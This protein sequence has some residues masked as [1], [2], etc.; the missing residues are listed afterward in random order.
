MP[1]VGQRKASRKCGLRGDDCVVFRDNVFKKGDELIT[2]PGVAYYQQLQQQIFDLQSDPLR[3]GQKPA[4][5]RLSTQ[6][7]QRLY[8][9]LSYH[10]RCCG[11]VDTGLVK[12]A[13][14]TS[15]SKDENGVEEMKLM[16]S[17]VLRACDACYLEV[18]GSQYPLQTGWCDRVHT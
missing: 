1:L 5:L 4:L 3:A 14:Q 11:R 15:V 16:H 9:C 18:M 7:R 10:L 12:S 2:C 13:K 8:T 6:E 17:F